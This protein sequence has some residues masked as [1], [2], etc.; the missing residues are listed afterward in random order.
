MGRTIY[1]A[2][3]RA[4]SEICPRQSKLLRRSIEIRLG[5]AKLNP[6]LLGSVNSESRQGR[7]LLAQGVSPGEQ[8]TD[9]PEPRAQ[10]VG[11]R[12][13]RRKFTEDAE[14]TIGKYEVSSFIGEEL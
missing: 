11:G 1:I 3:F 9:F 4:G 5:R 7:Q 10:R 13:P 14:T 2:R 12:Q 8:S 6:A